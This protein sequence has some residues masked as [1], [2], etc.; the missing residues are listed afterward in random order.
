[1]GLT[2]EGIGAVERGETLTLKPRTAK[3]LA[4]VL[5]VPEE[6]WYQAMGVQMAGGAST[7]LEGELLQIFRLVPADL[8]P[9]LVNLVRD[10]SRRLVEL[11]APQKPRRVG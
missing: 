11:P 10:T 1:M 2:R 9:A 8:Q 5:G 6:Q 4:E 3:R 7:P